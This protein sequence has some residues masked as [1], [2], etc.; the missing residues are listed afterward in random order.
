MGA[1]EC[2][3]VAVDIKILNLWDFWVDMTV[4]KY[5]PIIAIVASDVLLLCIQSD[6][7]TTQSKLDSRNMTI[8]TDNVD[9]LKQ[10]VSSW[11]QLL[12]FTTHF[13]LW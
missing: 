1:Y 13:A 10:Q 3:L 12:G 8:D 11:W 5:I 4:Q 2:I 7:M 6:D 9:I